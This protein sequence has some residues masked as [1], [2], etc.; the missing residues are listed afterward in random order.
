[1]D[2]HF[3]MKCRRTGMRSSRR[4]RDSIN[5]SSGNLIMGNEYYT[6]ETEQITTMANELQQQHQQEVTA[7]TL[8][9]IS[10]KGTDDQQINLSNPVTEQDE[11][12]NTTLHSTNNKST[13]V[14]SDERPFDE[15]SNDARTLQRENYNLRQKISQLE[16]TIQTLEQENKQHTNLIES[17]FELKAKSKDLQN[18]QSQTNQSYET[19]L[20]EWKN[21]LESLKQTPLKDTTNKK[22]KCTVDETNRS[23]SS[24]PISSSDVANGN[25]K[26][27]IHR[28]DLYQSWHQ[29][30]VQKSSKH[31]IVNGKGGDLYHIIIQD[32]SLFWTEEQIN[33]I[34]GKEEDKDSLSED[35][36]S[37]GTKSNCFPATKKNKRMVRRQLSPRQLETIGI[38]PA[39]SNC[40]AKAMQK[41]TTFSVSHQAGV[42]DAYCESLEVELLE[43]EGILQMKF[44]MITSDSVKV[45]QM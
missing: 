32:D 35:T 44:A 37:S 43:Y 5:Q 24:L 31:K 23:K 6:V 3:E 39:D 18:K 42:W 20:M 9:E 36:T 22:V 14:E 2:T 7:P 21:H 45:G 1:M 16:G 40:K 26:K 17:I 13:M 25:T 15:V 10:V 12:K 29:Q 41:P 28:A 19:K 4:E 8:E 30:L 27:I 11:N 38:L 33:K 34:F